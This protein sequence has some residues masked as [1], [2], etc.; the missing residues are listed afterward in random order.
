M[1]NQRPLA[2]GDYPALADLYSAVEPDD[3]I[4]AERLLQRHEEEDPARTLAR[5]VVLRGNRLVG[6]AELSRDSQ[7]C[8]DYTVNLD[9]KVHPDDRRAGAGRA[10]WELAR[11]QAL[12]AGVTEMKTWLRGEWA[13]G[14]NFA[15]Q[16]GFVESMREALQ[17]LDL[18][19]FDPKAFQAVCDSTS[20]GGVVI[21]SVADL[22]DAGWERSLWELENRLEE[23]VPQTGEF[24]PMAWEEWRR[25][26]PQSPTFLPHL[27]QVARVDGDYAGLTMLWPSCDGFLHTGLTG[28][29]REYRRMG[30][31]TALKVRALSR[32]QEAGYGRVKTE[33][34]CTNSAM[35]GVNR[36]LGF[37]VTGSYIE[38]TANAPFEG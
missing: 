21:T 23:D 4:T 7:A 27:W 11:R 15:E 37:E 13:A 29:R 14:L 16:R 36:R 25:R 18:A 33:N 3:P 35:L 6:C 10:L 9:L 28:V 31:A 8:H 30:I 12:D 19:R 5:T 26:R 17:A 20:A 24:T 2:A 34:A 22:D 38:M 32:A 1:F